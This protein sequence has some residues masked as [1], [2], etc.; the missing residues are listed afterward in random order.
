MLTAATF[1]K[2]EKWSEGRAASFAV[3]AP[4]RQRVRVL[5]GV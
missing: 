2:V 3:E 4:I 1:N 5:A